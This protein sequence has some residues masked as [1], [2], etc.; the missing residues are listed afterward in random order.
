VPP[1]NMVNSAVICTVAARGFL[2]HGANAQADPGVEVGGEMRC[3]KGCFPPDTKEVW[4][5]GSAFFPENFFRS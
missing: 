4:G 1:L 2:P 5:G 3:G